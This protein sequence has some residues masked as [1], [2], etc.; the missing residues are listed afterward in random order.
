MA[1][2]KMQ[3]TRVLS[4]SPAEVFEAWTNPEIL[5][6]WFAPGEMSAEVAELDARPGGTYRVA[7]HHPN[8]ATHVVHGSYRE[9]KPNESLVFTWAWEGV[10]M[11]DTEVSVELRP[12]GG[13]TELVLTHEGFPVAELRDQHIHGWTGSLE[14][15]GGLCSAVVVG[16][17]AKE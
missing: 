10:E 13:D 15:L 3:L 16:E 14:K 17:A 5:S 11:P 2:E 8:G 12:H 9:V 7:M 6:R 1:D 4:A